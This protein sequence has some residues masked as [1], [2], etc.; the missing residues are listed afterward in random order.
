M[1][2]K[3]KSSKSKQHSSSLDEQLREA[4]GVSNIFQLFSQ[5]SD[6]SDFDAKRGDCL[7]LDLF[8]EFS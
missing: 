7:H 5:K 3:R 8:S 6:G 2:A 1:G 4:F